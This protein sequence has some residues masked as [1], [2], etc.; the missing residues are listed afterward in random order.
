MLSYV[1]QN[2]HAHAHLN[3]KQINPTATTAYHTDLYLI[4]Y[5]AWRSTSVFEKGVG[6]LSICQTLTDLC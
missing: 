6:R 3:F 5:I 1:S 2:Q 4:I